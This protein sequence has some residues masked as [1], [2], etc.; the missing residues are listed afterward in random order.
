M[1]V[2]LLVT[3]VLGTGCLGGLDDTNDDVAMAV[4][5]PVVPTETEAVRLTAYDGATCTAGGPLASGGEALEEMDGVVLDYSG[6][7]EESRT[8]AIRVGTWVF[9]AVAEDA[10]G[11]DIA[12]GCAEG[13]VEE[14]ETLRLSIP[15]VD[16][17]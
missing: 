14:G 9:E 15:L 7:S 17:P 11:T 5:L 13:T 10:G 12:G 1:R 16:I 6:N 4:R 3:L 8:I 2:V